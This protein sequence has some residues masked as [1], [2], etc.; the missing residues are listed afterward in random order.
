MVFSGTVVNVGQVII[1]F[2]LTFKFLKSK[3]AEV[4]ELS[5]LCKESIGQSHVSSIVRRSEFES[6]RIEVEPYKKVKFTNKCPD[7]VERSLPFEERF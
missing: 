7:K 5:K 3:N 4:I 1:K 6:N 2:F